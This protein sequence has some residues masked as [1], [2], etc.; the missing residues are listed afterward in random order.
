MLLGLVGRRAASRVAAL[1]AVLLGVAGFSSTLALYWLLLVRQRCL[2]AC[3]CVPA[4]S[5]RRSINITLRCAALHHAAP[6]CCGNGGRPPTP[7]HPGAQV[8]FLQRGP[9]PPC[10][11]EL[12]GISDARLRAAAILALALPLL[13]LLPY[14][15][16]GAPV[17]DLLGSPPLELM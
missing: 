15:F 7:G 12:G 5:I 17:A 9:V 14:P 11:Q 10:Q 16:A 2:H 4:G 6:C 8:L 13:V 3:C 1:T